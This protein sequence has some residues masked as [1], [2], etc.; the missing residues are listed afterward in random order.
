VAIDSNRPAWESSST[1]YS[2]ITHT[3]ELCEVP[4][5]QHLVEADSACTFRYTTSQSTVYR[6]LL[7][8]SKLWR[9]VLGFAWRRWKNPAFLWQSI[10]NW[11]KL[12]SVAALLL[13]VK[14]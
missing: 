4:A 14:S 13:F 9:Y 5:L 6:T 8:G 12:L 3:S 11:R 10:A 2:R 7:G 1:P